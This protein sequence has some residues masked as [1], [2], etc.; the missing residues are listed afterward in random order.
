[1]KVVYHSLKKIIQEEEKGLLPHV[2]FEKPLAHL[3]EDVQETGQT[4]LELRKVGQEMY[5][6]KYSPYFIN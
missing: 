2:E 6:P 5:L 3:N 4:G 1:M